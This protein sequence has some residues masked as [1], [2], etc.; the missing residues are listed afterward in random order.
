MKLIK[1]PILVIKNY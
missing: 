1:T